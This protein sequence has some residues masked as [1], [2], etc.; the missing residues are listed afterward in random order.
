MGMNLKDIFRKDDETLVVDRTKQALRSFIT[1]AVIVTIMLVVVVILRNT[2]NVD[3]NRR[4]AITRD[5]QNIQHYVRNK[6]SDVKENPD[7][8]LPGK[9][10]EEEPITLNVNGIIEEYRYGYYLLSPEDYS[11]MATALNI[12]GEYYIVNYDT[13]DV[14]NCAGIKYNK[15]MYYS[16]DDLVA[17]DTKQLIPS[18]NTIIIKVAEDMKKLHQYPNAN[19]K[20]AGNIDMQTYSAGEGWDPVDEF[21]GTLDGRGYT[22]SNL[23][24]DRPTQTYVGLFGEANSKSRIV[25]LTFKDVKV[26]GET[27]TGV[28]A[29]TMYGNINNVIIEGGT[30]T[31]I[32]KV[33][34]LVG[35]HQQGTITT[36]KVILETV[37]GENQ[38]GG[39]VGIL[40]SG[41]VQEVMAKTNNIYAV[42]SVGGFVGAIS[43]TNPTYF[44]ECSSTSTCSG[45]ES[46]GGLVGKIEILSN[47]NL[48]IN[49]CY[50]K[51]TISEGEKN[52]GGLVG[53]IRTSS[54]AGIS[55]ED[56]YASVNILN[57]VATAGG[58]VGYSNVSLGTSPTILGV[59]WEKNLAVGEVLNSV[60]TQATDTMRLDFT[61]KSYDEMRYRSTFADWDFDI[62]GINERVDSPYLKFENG[63]KQYTKEKER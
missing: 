41:T 4:V 23:M 17:I 25:N 62:W 35:S 21:S 27:Y 5:I 43:A 2:G 44:N 50:S 20:L 42:E 38:V 47:S 36:C 40:N 22:I 59:F 57:K 28:L 54:G 11:D 8:E 48:Y 24:I 30:V 32:D 16:V 3:E 51:G 29:G 14:I 46:I 33:G 39:A 31:G 63:F 26:I 1:L 56:L 53:Y 52:M 34:G 60:G 12:T 7:L 6:A 9:S 58:C 18:E 15:K 37:A 61:S 49:N 13:Y 45:R 10:L 19:F 55:F